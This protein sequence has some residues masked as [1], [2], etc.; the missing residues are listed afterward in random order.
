MLVTNIVWFLGLL[1]TYYYLPFF[2]FPFLWIGLLLLLLTVLIIQLFK[3]FRERKNISRLRVQK[4]VS[5]L[6]LFT[7]CMFYHKVAIAIEKVDWVIYS[8]KREGITELVKQ[9]SLNPNVSWNGWVCELPFEFPVISN[10]GNDIG[11]SRKANGAVTVTFWVSRNFFDAPSTY[12]IYS[13]DT[14]SIRRLEAKVK[15]KPEY[16]WK[17]KN[18]WYRIY[19]GY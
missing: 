1:A 8:A 5:F 3:L 14:A 6:I 15:Y 12:F 16:N 18:N 11:I 13:N 2:L 9:H 19:G 10:G 7:L 4:V 17:I